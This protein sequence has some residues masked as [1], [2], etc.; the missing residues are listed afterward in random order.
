MG[1]GE[2]LAGLSRDHERARALASALSSAQADD[3]KEL[4][5]RFLDSL[6]G[7]ERWH[8]CSE[9]AVLL[10][11]LP[12]DEIGRRLVERVLEDH[13]Y[14]RD[15]HRR[16]RRAS[17]PPDVVFLHALG[18]RLQEHVAMEEGELFGR[19]E[20]SLDAGALDELGA[21]LR[22]APNSTA[23]AIVGRFLDA[24][25]ARDHPLLLALV[26]PDIELHPP[27]L[28]SKHAYRGHAGLQ[29]WVDDL[30]VRPLD[31]SFTVEE[32]R[33]LDESRALARLKL[34][35]GEEEMPVFAV[36]TVTMGR[37]RAIRGYFSDEDLL[38]HVGHL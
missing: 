20:Q 29:A 26:D 1:C 33:E 5:R 3:A 30:R 7:C 2:A 9:E 19:L 31:L 16:V 12:Q 8:L 24:F 34:D 27:R 36:F 22:A 11:A 14:L 32:V 21:Q 4:A 37:V 18:N 28:G 6:V 10:P 17:E 23:A 25:A 38:A 35:L 15:A 13:S